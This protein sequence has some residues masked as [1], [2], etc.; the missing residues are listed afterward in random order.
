MVCLFLT[1]VF[2]ANQKS[3]NLYFGL[4]E[5]NKLVRH[6]LFF[7][8]QFYSGLKKWKNYILVYQA[9]GIQADIFLNCLIIKSFIF[10]ANLYI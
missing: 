10:T 7:E 3:K 4:S 1:S 2:L 5:I 8:K 9:Q 6:F